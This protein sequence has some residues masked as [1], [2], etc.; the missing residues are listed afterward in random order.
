[1]LLVHEL[2]VSHAVVHPKKAAII[3]ASDDRTWQMIDSSSGS[4][5]LSGRGHTDWLSSVK[6]SPNGKQLATSSGDRSVRIWD[7]ENEKCVAQF[8]DHTQAVWDIAYHS[9][10]SFLASWLVRVF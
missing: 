8:D 2:A 3:C 9:S 7:L 1:M 6:C 10:G 4:V 5:M